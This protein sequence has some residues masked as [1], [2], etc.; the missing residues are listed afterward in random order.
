[1]YEVFVHASLLF[2]ILCVAVFCFFSCVQLWE[3]VWGS[4]SHKTGR[5]I[6]PPSAAD[7]GKIALCERERQ[8]EKKVQRG[9]GERER[10]REREGEEEKVNEKQVNRLLASCHETCPWHTNSQSMT[11]IQNANSHHFSQLP[12]TLLTQHNITYI[13]RMNKSASKEFRHE[14]LQSLLRQRLQALTNL[15]PRNKQVYPA[16]DMGLASDWL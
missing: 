11:A 9:V 6:R 2:Q 16:Q 10:E 13:R 14:K 5:E 4:R 7:K 15:F 1:M 12:V 8:R 3:R